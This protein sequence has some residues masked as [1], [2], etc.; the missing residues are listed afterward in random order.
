MFMGHFLQLKILVSTALLGCPAAQLRVD[1]LPIGRYELTH[2][3]QQTLGVELVGSEFHRR[4][5]A[6]RLA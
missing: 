2:F 1:S 3:S 5:E 4:D 6:L